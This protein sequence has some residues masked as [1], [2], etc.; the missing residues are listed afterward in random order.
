MRVSTLRGSVACLS[1]IEALALAACN[2]SAGSGQVAAPRMVPR[3]SQAAPM[4][5]PLS[6]DMTSPDALAPVSISPGAVIGKD[7]IFKP[8]DGDQPAGGHG[9]Q[10]G[11]TTCDPKEHVDAYHVHAYLGLVVNQQQVAIPDTIGMVKPGREVNGYTRNAKCFYWIHTHD[12][13][14]MIH[15]EDP[16]TES[17]D[18]VIYRLGTFLKIWGVP[19]TSTSFGSFKGPIHVFVGNVPVI[20]QTTVSKYHA[21]TGSIA[22]IPLHSHTAIWIEV[23]AKYFTAAQLPEVTFYTE[24]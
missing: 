18:K 3:V 5:V 14:G 2:G 24:Y 8:R 23:G 4:G 1:A 6:N 15:I 11:K 16:N 21:Y 12:A 9:A 10:I 22:K 7:D 17:L 19:S 20:G 13:S